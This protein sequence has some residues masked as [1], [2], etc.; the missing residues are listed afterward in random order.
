MSAR[1]SPWEVTDSSP[2]TAQERQFQADWDIDVC[3]NGEIRIECSTD[4]PGRH[5]TTVTRA[6]LLRLLEW[7]P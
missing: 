7:K 1:P 6:M 2:P 3:Q 5:T 4:T